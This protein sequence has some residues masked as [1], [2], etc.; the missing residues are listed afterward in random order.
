MRP[1]RWR[2]DGAS[3]NYDWRGGPR[4]D[5]PPASGASRGSS[6]YRR[7]ADDGRPGALGG[8][9]ARVALGDFAR[10]PSA[11]RGTP[12]RAPDRRRARPGSTTTRHSRRCRRAQPDARSRTAPRETPGKHR[13]RAGT[14]SRRATARR[15]RACSG[16]SE[17]SPA[18]CSSQRPQERADRQRDQQ[19][20]PRHQRMQVGVPLLLERGARHES[21]NASQYR[22]W[23]TAKAAAGTSATDTSRLIEAARSV[24]TGIVAGR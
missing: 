16:A 23:C 5:Q 24:R 4:P 17:H 9:R 6:T 13:S 11:R 19:H 3:A 10:A 14:P 22:S 18:K 1:R 8:N 12:P 21:P 20:D 15:T 2:L 7:S